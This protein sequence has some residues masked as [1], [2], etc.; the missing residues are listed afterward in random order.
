VRI[1][2]SEA[3]YELGDQRL[4]INTLQDI[5]RIGIEVL[6]EKEQTIEGYAPEVF[7]L[8]HTLNV[9]NC[10][11]YTGSLLDKE[12]LAIAAKEKTDYSKRAAE[13]LAG[14]KP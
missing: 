9:V 6:V 8:T 3:L 7:E 1:A 10:L 13:Y 4:A 12:I 2:A 14:K 5:L 11:G